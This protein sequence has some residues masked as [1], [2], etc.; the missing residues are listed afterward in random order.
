MDPKIIINNI[1]THLNLLESL[2]N[3]VIILSLAIVWA[4][5]KRKQHIELLGNTFDRRHAFF[6]V[7]GFYLVINIS[8]LLIFLRTGDLILLLKD[9][10]SL[11]TGIT[12]F[13][14]HRWL[15]NPYSYFSTNK[16]T[17][18][19]F[20]YSS[21]GLGMLILVWWICTASLYSLMDDKNN[22]TA[23]ILI[24][25][26]VAIGICSVFTIYRGFNNVM[27]V[28]KIFLTDTETYGLLQESMR[29]KIIGAAAGIISGIAFFITTYLFQKKWL[30]NQ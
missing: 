1:A 9:K 25:L 14:T 2:V 26:F 22:V 3:T 21:L 15:L 27:Q 4:G 24:G 12:Q 29:G 8:V 6:I 13:S 19:Q 16:L 23:Q 7:A 30:K 5:I 17:C 11:I 28:S 10:D 20:A 18:V